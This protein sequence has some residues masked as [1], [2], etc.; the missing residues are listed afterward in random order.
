LGRLESFLCFWLCS[1]I[2][3]LYLEKGC[4]RLK[5]LFSSVSLVVV[6]HFAVCCYRNT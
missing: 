5:G 3:D 2:G 4:R 1:V 6:L